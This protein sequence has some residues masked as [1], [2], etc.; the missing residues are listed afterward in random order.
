MKSISLIFSLIAGVFASG[1]VHAAD[2]GITGSFGSN[3][4]GVHLTFPLKSNL[5][6]RIGANAGSYSFDGSTNTASYT[7]KAHAETYD[8]LLDFYPVANAFRVTGGMVYNNNRLDLQAR[9]NINGNFGF[10]GNTYTVADA[11]TVNGKADFKKFAPYVGIG[12]GNAIG[13]SKWSFSAD[14]GVMFQGRA[15][16]SLTNT[17]CTLDTM[18]WNSPFSSGAGLCDRLAADLSTENSK[19][20]AKVGDYKILPVAYVGISYKF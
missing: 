9:S 17:G 19:L 4:A 5:N 12:F 20:Q 3:G 2:V 8:A 1:A 18:S 7:V 11:G 16:T 13:K 15:R 10:N 14:L 6:A